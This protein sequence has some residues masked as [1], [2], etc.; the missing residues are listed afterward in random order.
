MNTFRTLIT[1][2]ELQ[3]LLGGSGAVGQSARSAAPAIEPVLV[4][5][6]FSLAD[7]EAGRRAYAEGHIPDAVYAHVN[8]DLSGE[9]VPGKTG[10]HPLPDPDRFARAA[11]R[12]GIEPN[13]QIIAYDDSGGAM[14]ARFW[15]LL[16]WL[17]HDE[18]AVLDGGIRAW[19]EAGQSARM[20]G[21][22]N[23]WAGTLSREV[24]DHRSGRFE[25]RPRSEL[26]VDTAAV[27]ARRTEPNARLL[28]ARAPERFR[29]E[30]EPI[31][32]VAGHIPGAVSLPFE[33]LVHDGRF[34]PVDEIKARFASA[35]GAVT[36]DNAI[37]YCG[38]G[39]T[40]C[41]LVL[42][43]AHAGLEG[44]LLYPGSWSEWITDPSRPVARG[45]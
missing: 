30:I 22:R 1:A 17:G 29:G 44:V 41:H 25:P 37:A 26:I 14:A 19:L 8:Q 31:D 32:P 9:V 28:D 11:E 6:R 13:R 40:A 38:S 34:R 42:A 36:P 16:R 2:H 3:H 15:W 33:S 24:P 23:T 5:C 39:V 45:G 4:D 7:A 35:L 43:A 27:D 18:V 10:R 12:W 20:G 21:A